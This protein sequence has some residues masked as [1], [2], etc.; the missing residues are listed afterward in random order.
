[1]KSSRGFVFQG[2]IKSHFVRQNLRAPKVNLSGSF[3]LAMLTKKTAIENNIPNSHWTITQHYSKHSISHVLFIAVSY[4]FFRAV[5]SNWTKNKVHRQ[6]FVEKNMLILVSGECSFILLA[7]ALEVSPICT[8]FHGQEK[9][10]SIVLDYEPD[11]GDLN[12]STTLFQQ[13]ILKT[14]LRV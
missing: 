6:F 1:M 12:F 10:Y 11:N 5:F 4:V 13:D 9:E 3:S 8:V 14:A 2:N 7:T